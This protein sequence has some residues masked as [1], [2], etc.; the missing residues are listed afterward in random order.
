M[1]ADTIQIQ[2]LERDS[3]SSFLVVMTDNAVL[4]EQCRSRNGVWLGLSTPLPSQCES[5]HRKNTT[6]ALRQK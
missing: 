3:G 5:A 1:I 2:P 6:S 4:I